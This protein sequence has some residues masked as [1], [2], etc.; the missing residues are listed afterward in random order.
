MNTSKILNADFQ[1]MDNYEPLIKDHSK[2]KEMKYKLLRV[3]EKTFADRYF[4]LKIGM[5]NT[6]EDMCFLATSRGYFCKDITYFSQKHDVG[7][8]TIERN[9]KFLCDEKVLV[10]KHR[11]SPKHNGLGT[12]I[13]FFIDHPY[14]ELWNKKI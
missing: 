7:K 1:S 11:T 2:R 13:Y 12:P 10:K 14:F 5:Q 9:L 3:I 4:N 8:S 6:F